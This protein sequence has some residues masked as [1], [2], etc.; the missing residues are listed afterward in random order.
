MGLLS[1]FVGVI[2]SPKATFQSVVAHPRWFGMLLLTC[3]AVSVL[4]G[5]FLMTKV[6]QD[7]W[8][9][10]AD[11]QSVQPRPDV[12]I[13][14][15]RGMA[16]MAPYV[17]IRSRSFKCSSCC[18]SSYAGQRRASCTWSSR[19]CRAAPR[20][21]K[22]LFA[23]VVHTGV[24]WRPGAA[25]HGADELTAGLDVEQDQPRGPPADDGRE[26]FLGRLL[27]MIDLF[28]IWWLVVLAIGLGVL[29]RR[30]TQPIAIG[31]FGRLWR[32]RVDDCRRDES[33]WRNELTRNKKILIGGGVVVVLAARRLRELQ[34]QAGRRR[35]QSTP[36]HPE[37]R[38]RGDRLGVG[39]DPAEALRQHQRRHD[40]PRD[41]AGGQRRRSRQAGTVPAADRPA[42]PAHARRRAAKPRSARRDRSSSRCGCR[43]TARARRSSRPRT[44]TAAS[45]TSE[46]RPDDD[47]KRSSGRRTI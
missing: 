37:A 46:G 7:A 47:A 4:V 23:V 31:L 44:P 8:L 40:G 11:K 24:D 21:F 10:A 35:R 15:M 6:G 41:R 3:A 30:R 14:S 36:S 32:H 16:R 27:G 39:Q 33:V 34:V 28:L 2:T 45:R 1:R 38:S 19:S 22:Q 5:G 17:G 18:R 20:S 13:S 25:L 9:D 29:Y 43:S 26:S 42:Q 12:A